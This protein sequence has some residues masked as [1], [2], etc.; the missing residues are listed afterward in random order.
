MLTQK[1]IAEL[2]S[3]RDQ[4]IAALDKPQVK[5]D[6]YTRI[7][8]EAQAALEDYA[9][10]VMLKT[11]AK[12]YT[13]MTDEELTAEYQV[14]E[15]ANNAASSWGAAVGVRDEFMKEIK[16]EQAKRY[17]QKWKKN[18]TTPTWKYPLRTCAKCGKVIKESTFYALGDD[19]Y[20]QDC[21]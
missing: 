7:C 16:H 13:E 18:L 12:P 6:T 10:T 11:K 15:E 19:Y 21:A 2:R 5:H 9:K 20:H 8:V 3:L 17:A 1:Q 4:I 14:L